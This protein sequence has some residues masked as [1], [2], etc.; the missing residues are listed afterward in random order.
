MSGFLK[1]SNVVMSS[2]NM[3]QPF[4]IFL[5]VLATAGTWANTTYT[6]KY[7]RKGDRLVCDGVIA[8]SGATSA[9]PLSFTL[10]NSLQ[11]DTVKIS[12]TNFGHPLEGSARL[13]DTTGSSYNAFPA[14]ADATTIRLLQWDASNN[15]SNITSG[16]PFTWAS[17]DF[18][19]VNFEVPISGWETYESSTPNMVVNVPAATQTSYAIEAYGNAGQTLIANVTDIPFA[20]V[21]IQDNL[22]W[23]GS[24]FTAPI[25]GDYELMGQFACTVGVTAGYASAYINGVV[26]K[27]IGVGVSTQITGFNG[28]FRLLAGQRLSV[29]Y[30]VGYTLLNSTTSHWISITRVNG[31]NDS[32]VIANTSKEQLAYIRTVA[33]DNMTGGRAA[34]TSYKTLPLISIEGDAFLSLSSNR[35]ALPVGEYDIEVPLGSLGGSSGP[36]WVHLNVYNFTGSSNVKQ[37]LQVAYGA[38][39]SVMSFNTARFKLSVTTPS[40]YEFQSKADVADGTEW[41]GTI[42]I[43]KIA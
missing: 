15:T 13:F 33:G 24:G 23:D 25:S 18:I 11:I 7:W 6:F 39:G 41:F 16:S 32:A 38:S 35:A 20:T 43:R 5:G 8:I 4:D 28:K 12:N 17:G 1:N 30:G 14:Y 26:S 31:R 29:R 22:T 3:R 42:K 2:S 37:I 27:V 21:S 40:S 36:N 34:T 19:E 10:P 9:T